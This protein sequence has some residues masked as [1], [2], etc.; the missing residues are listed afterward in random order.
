M[1]QYFTAILSCIRR[2]LNRPKRVNPFLKFPNDLPDSNLPSIIDLEIKNRSSTV[3]KVV[4]FGANETLWQKNHGNHP[5]IEIT[6]QYH[7][8]HTY[9]GLLAASLGHERRGYTIRMVASAEQRQQTLKWLSNDYFGG[10]FNARMVVPKNHFV[11]NSQNIDDSMVDIHDQF[12][13]DSRTALVFDMLPKSEISLLFYIYPEEKPKNKYV[14]F[15][16]DAPFRPSE[17]R[18]DQ[19]QYVV[20]STAKPAFPAGFFGRIAAMFR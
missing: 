4:L 5:H 16:L 10:A 12:M 13:I 20:K 11:E 3:Q 6:A 18:Y 17:I 14:P 9:G 15:V 2:L 19:G 7:H 8:S 1:K